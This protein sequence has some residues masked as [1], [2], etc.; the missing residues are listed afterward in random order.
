M[1]FF[2][3]QKE[4]IFPILVSRT[5]IFL[6]FM[7]ILTLL[8]YTA[9]TVQE[10]IDSTQVSLLRFYSVLGIF[11]AIISLCGAILDL[12]R[13]LK[14]RK[15]RYLLRAGGYILLVIFSVTTVLAA[16]LIITLST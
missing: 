16:V 12:G 11:L 4:K 13:F 10:F 7:A 8:L 5:M 9:G 3:Y 6:F 14:I 15:P 2:G 1:F